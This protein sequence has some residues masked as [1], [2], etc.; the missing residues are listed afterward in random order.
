MRKFFSFIKNKYI[1]TLFLLFIWL[2][3]FDKYDLIEQ[4][5]S[6]R[7][8]KDLKKE[9][10]YYLEEIEKNNKNIIELKTHPENLEKFARE[11][12]LMKR[13]NEDIFIIVD[14]NKE[15]EPLLNKN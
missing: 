3:F 15:K 10:Q 13:E 4:Y 12:Y 9:K 11:K 6:K 8:L 2:L 7:K 5:Q 14:N 1:I